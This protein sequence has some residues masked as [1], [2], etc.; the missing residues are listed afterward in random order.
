VKR[1]TFIVGLGSAA[2]WPVLAQAQQPAMPVIG[3]LASQS[4]EVE[5]NVTVA[6]LRG[7]KDAG[8]VE[9]RTWRSSIGMRT[10]KF[11]GSAR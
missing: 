5:H 4:A 7:L 8:Y 10:I 9:G 6:F 11:S 2:A 3:F 1:R